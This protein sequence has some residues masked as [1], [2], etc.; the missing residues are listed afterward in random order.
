MEARRFSG[1]GS[2]HETRFAPRRD[3]QGPRRS[4]GQLFGD[5]AQQMQTLFRLEL[6]LARVETTEQVKRA[7]RGGGMIAA[8]AAVAYGGFLAVI[9]ALAL[10]LGSAMP[11]WLAFLLTGVLVLLAGA[12]LFASGRSTLKEADFNLDKTARTLEEDARWIKHEA[13]E[14][15]RDPSHLGS[16]RVAR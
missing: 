1:N 3:A 5:L 8:A 12:L 10:L 11:M 7:G 14:V 6:Q 9:A 13:A 15:K 4:V 16:Q 2:G